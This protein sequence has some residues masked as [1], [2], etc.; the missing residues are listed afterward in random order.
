MCVCHLCEMRAVSQRDLAL[1]SCIRPNAPSA[2]PV[3]CARRA[4]R[5]AQ[6]IQAVPPAGHH[7]FLPVL[8]PSRAALAPARAMR[9]A[10][11]WSAS[12]SAA[13]AVLFCSPFL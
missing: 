10:S 2:I 9:A 3:V 4:R 7:G 5:G 8:L 6:P 13:R 12:Q 1:P 11:V